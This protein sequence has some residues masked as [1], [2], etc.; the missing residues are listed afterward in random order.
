MMIY[1]W[2][3]Q[4]V[5]LTLNWTRTFRYGDTEEGSRRTSDHPRRGIFLKSVLSWLEVESW[6]LE[7]KS[8]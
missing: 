8:Q 4:K 2:K 1:V 7:D 5:S 3:E 6:Q